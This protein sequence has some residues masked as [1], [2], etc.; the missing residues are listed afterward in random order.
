MT[1]DPARALALLEGIGAAAAGRA[2][3]AS[4]DP[5]ARRSRVKEKAAREAGRRASGGRTTVLKVR[6]RPQ[7]KAEIEG[8]AERARMTASALARRRLLGVKVAF[9]PPLAAL[10]HLRRA[11][12]LAQA[13]AAESAGA[14]DADIAAILAAQR[15]AMEALGAPERPG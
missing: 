12:V 11:C 3:S 13:L 7:E 6:L 4:G 8:L 2:S 9:Q 14:H 10:E 15:A 1:P 5:P